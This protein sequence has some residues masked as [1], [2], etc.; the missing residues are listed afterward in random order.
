[1][2]LNEIKY[3]YPE[4]PVLILIESEA[5]ERFSNDP[6]YV[7]EPKYNGSR[8]EVH[9]LDGHVEFWD[10]HGKHLK[11]NSDPLHE[12]ERNELKK[13]LVT[14]FGKK[15]YFVLDG[16]LRHNKVSGIQNKLVIYDIHIFENEVLNKLVFG[17]RRSIL[18]QKFGEAHGYFDKRILSLIH[19]YK[20]DFQKVFDDYVAGFYG[21]PEEYE[22]I[23]IKNLNSK[24]KLGRASGTDSIWMFKVRKATGRH[25]Y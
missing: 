18:E 25:R 11:Y 23:V 17:S 24:L 16:E 15:G 8:C 6:D 3:F 7:A 21:D 2:R 9:I 13:A 5:F 20:T 19:Q 1:M 14:V 12:K 10:R 4:K 22:G